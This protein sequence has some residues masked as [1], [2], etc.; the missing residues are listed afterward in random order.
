MGKKKPVDV[1]AVGI[2]VAKMELDYHLLCLHEA[3]EAGDEKGRVMNLASIAHV[4]DRLIKLGY[5]RIPATQS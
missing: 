4:R 5:Y 3:L 1:T 2:K